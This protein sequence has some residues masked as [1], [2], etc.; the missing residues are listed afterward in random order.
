MLSISVQAQ[1]LYN[2]SDN[3]ASPI[4]GAEA[5][6]LNANSRGSEPALWEDDFSDPLTWVFDND[7]QAAPFGW[8]ISSNAV[9]WW[10]NGITSTSGGNFAEL[11]NGDPTLTPETQALD[12]I[13]TITTAQPI[14]V[15]T[16]AGTDN[17]LLTFEQFGARFN[18]E[19]TVEISTDGTTFTQVYSNVGFAMLTSTGG[20]AYP[21][22][23]L[24]VVDIAPYIS[25][26]ANTVWLRFK[27]T[28]AFP[29]ETTTPNAWITY[30]WYI[31]DVRIVS[32]DAHDLVLDFG[33]ISHNQTGAEFGRVPVGQLY[34]E[35]LFG[36]SVRNF[37]F[38]DQTNVNL[39][40]KVLGAQQQELFNDNATQAT[41]PSGDTATLELFA[42]S[43]LFETPGRYTVEFETWSD[44]DT[45]GTPTYQDNTTS[46]R[47]EVTDTLYSLDG[48]GGVHISAAPLES[49]GNNSFSATV[50]DDF[51][52]LVFYD[53]INPVDVK[54]I[55]VMLA[56]GTLKDATFFVSLFRAED[57]EAETTLGLPD[58]YLAQSEVY[59]VVANVTAQNMNGTNG[60]PR[61][62]FDAPETL[63]AGGYYAA[64]RTV[65]DK[66]V[67]LRDDVTV[68]QPAGTSLIYVP[69]DQ[70]VFTNSNAFGI[71]LIVEG[72]LVGVN[73]TSNL[74]HS[75]NVYPNP[76]NGSSIFIDVEAD[77]SDQLTLNVFSVQGALALTQQLNV[78]AGFN[79]TSINVDGLTNGL[80]F[81]QLASKDGQSTSKLVVNH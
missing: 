61:I 5:P 4:K 23:N 73:E 37:G 60:S 27:W 32:K 71:R 79:R 63:E 55:Q 58:L 53:I 42:A 48:L 46:R 64:V 49:I 67:R 1:S 52:G 14:D 10:S 62:Y 81:V 13:Y 25:G 16:L 72:T 77:K 78:S 6:L 51:M 47:F 57:V 41:L 20:A 80:Y 24:Q 45:T 59:D 33:Y 11:A 76:V 17:V 39:N 19:Q 29:D 18:D 70:T 50:L 38:E 34:P 28:S 40:I 31:D 69:D 56:P 65:G 7:G 12:V 30:G 54:G 43:S 35:F 22:P 75:V 15:Q 9:G 26:N 8:S 74:S 68:P 36:G 2:L 66:V 21:N 44:D 3:I